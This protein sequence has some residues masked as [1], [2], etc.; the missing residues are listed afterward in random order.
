LA[1]RGVPSIEEGL[2]VLS[3]LLEIFMG[4][5]IK[6]IAKEGLPPAAEPIVSSGTGPGSL[7]GCVREFGYNSI[8]YLTRE[9]A[10]EAL[11]Q[12]IEEIDKGEDGVFN[13]AYWKECDYRWTRNQNMNQEIA[14]YR[15]LWTH[16]RMDPELWWGMYKRERFRED[17]FR[18]FL[19]YKAGY[20]IEYEP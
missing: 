1:R 7:L 13:T 5:S 14:E 17:V 20:D 12:V 18:F 16:M 15:M 6:V 8:P 9:Q 19:Y 11:L 2:K 4:Y 10:C 3:L